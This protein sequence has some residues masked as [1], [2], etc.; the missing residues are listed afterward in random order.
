MSTKVREFVFDY[1][2]A[3]WHEI[4]SNWKVVLFPLNGATFVR[5]IY[6]RVA[7]IKIGQISNYCYRACSFIDS[8]VELQMAQVLPIRC[9]TCDQQHEEV[10]SDWCGCVWFFHTLTPL[11]DQ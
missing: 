8:C 1:L 6:L 5:D 11:F 10:V 4:L 2:V 3:F 7:P 9:L